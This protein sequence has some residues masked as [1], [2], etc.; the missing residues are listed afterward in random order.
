MYLE[1]MLLRP[2]GGGS[3]T[4]QEI[5]RMMWGT[6]LSR[7]TM[8]HF[9][10]AVAMLLL[11]EALMAAGYAYPVL[12]L[13]APLGLVAVH[14][15]VLGWLSL[16]ML[17]ALYQFVPVIT[18]K[19]LWSQRLALASLAAIAGGVAAMAAGFLGL[20]GIGAAPAP[21]LPAGGALVIVGFALAATD[22]G[23]TLWRGRPLPLP[24]R[25]VAAGLCFLLV[26]GTLGLIF[27]CALTVAHAPAWTQTVLA[28]GLPVHVAAG[29]GGWFT[30]TAMGVSYR[31][32]SMFMLAPEADG[33][34][35][36]WALRLSVAGV[37]L[38]V[39]GGLLDPDATAASIA[40]PAGEAI[41][42]VGLALYA[43]DMLRLYRT[44]R[45]RL[46]E[47]NSKTA[48][49][50]LGFLAVAAAGFAIAEAT[51]RTAALIGP[52]GYL[53]VFG[54]LSGL[55]LGQLYKIVPFLTWLERFGPR[56]G[57][58]PVPRVQ[59]LVDER[60]AAPWFALYFLAVLGAALTIAVGLPV[61]T[62]LAVALQLVASCLIASELWR[63]RRAD[64]AAVPATAPPSSKA[65]L[66]PAAA[67][68]P[69][70]HSGSA[71]SR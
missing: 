24:A 63:A 12:D 51:G 33:R 62:R 41:A 44:R 66:A 69:S 30:L 61:A 20:A 64:P 10:V 35:S 67:T 58:G 34:T 3:A 18:G 38:I 59:D 21:W 5:A 11:A 9:F 22:L 57:K 13:R 56:M 32:L 45:R 23:A 53:F 47:L 14:L 52:I 19:P 8:A 25:F 49:A 7:W 48:A 16:L 55:G 43:A 54:W 70:P 60:R 4:H 39:A 65:R 31:L 1:Y 6:S 37:A 27:A 36:N 17:G 71:H 29:L 15:I 46:L 68:P 40:L 28:R 50:A 26:T 42:G 2:P